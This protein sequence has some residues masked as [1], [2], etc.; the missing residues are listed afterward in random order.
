[1][2]RPSDHLKP[3]VWVIGTASWLQESAF[4]NLPQLVHPDIENI[5]LMQARQYP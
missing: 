2:Y 3:Q 4:T 1:M 5:P